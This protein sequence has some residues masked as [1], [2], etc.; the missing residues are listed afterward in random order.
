MKDLWKTALLLAVVAWSLGS[1][2]QQPQP[3]AEPAEAADVATIR[4]L[5]EAQT[6][7]W[8]RGDLEGYMQGYW[9]SGELT[10]FSGAS[11]TAGWEKT[12]Q[13]YKRAY[14]SGGRQMGRLSYREI[15]V[16]LL[17][18]DAAF[19]RGKWQLKMREGASPQGVFTLVL[20]RFPEGWK[21]VH[22]HS[23]GD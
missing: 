7:A 5:L 12:L 20:K 8:N 9:R 16:E 3:K 21:I 6:S 4:A 14:K 18:A 19:V 1:P 2:A 13:R 17:G 15:K 10:F 11:R 22:D 23:S